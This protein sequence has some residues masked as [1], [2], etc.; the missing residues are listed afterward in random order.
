MKTNVT[1]I[2]ILGVFIVFLIAGVLIFSMAGSSS[3]SASNVQVEIWG[4]IPDA[5]V[6][7]VVDTV[8][9]QRSGT[10]NLYYKEIPENI[11]EQKL[12][13]AL[14]DGDGPDVV[15]IPSNMILKNQKKFLTIGTDFITTRDFKDSF[16]EA[17]EIFLTAKGTYALPLYTDPMVMYWNRD[18]LTA[19]NVARPP[20][21]WEEVLR[22]VNVLTERREDRS[23]LKSALAMGDNSNIPF[24][25][26]M[27]ITLLM[28]AG[29]RI[30]ER[31]AD[32]KPISLLA[33]NQGMEMNPLTS[34]LTFY[35]QFSNPVLDM[36][37]W[38]RSLPDAEIAFAN[39]D[40]AFY[41]APTSQAKV[42]RTKNPNLNFDIAPMPQPKASTFKR[43]FGTV[44]GMSI[45]GISENANA[46]FATMQI[47]AS[48]EVASLFSNNMGVPPAR[49]DLLS[50]VPV[51]TF[52]AVF[53]QSALWAKA[54]LDPDPT[55]TDMLFKDS[56]DAVVTGA[57]RVDD[58]SKTLIKQLS[59]LIEVEE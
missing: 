13:E 53:W 19:K 45:V 16:N 54:W 7:R 37:S 1:Q 52:G 58:A 59:E 11:F 10:L 24:A 44:Y 8:N 46:A 48:A 18:M 29:G 51:N 49:R 28:Q 55:K 2:I 23:I 33:S 22:L 20:T 14:A 6:A 17:S 3:D 35:T 47:L 31:D 27:I 21:N 57:N 9:N 50:E 5:S 25:K 40:V 30:I 34:A 42:I 36:Y 43:T 12:I 4:T 56:V 39:G 38:N 41:F 26:N 15:I 32:D